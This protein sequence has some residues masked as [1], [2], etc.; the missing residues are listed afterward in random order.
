[1]FGEFG[2]RQGPYKNFDKEKEQWKIWRE[3]ILKK[4]SPDSSQ[5]Q[6][7]EQDQ[8]EVEELKKK[9]EEQRKKAEEQDQN[10]P[11]LNQH[12]QDQPTEP[13]NKDNSPPP[14]TQENNNLPSSTEIQ[15]NYNSDNNPNLTNPEQK[16]QANELL[17]LIITAELLI[18]ET[19]FDSETLSKLTK[20]KEESTTSYQ[21]LNK[22]GRIDKVI[23]AL[24][25]IQKSQEDKN[26]LVAE[27]NKN[28]PISLSTK[29]FLGTA[30][31][32]GS[33]ILGIVVMQIIKR[34]KI[35]R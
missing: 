31:I 35:K 6:Q 23:N 20:E 8:K 26:N 10:N 29:I 3:A 19:K 1:L 2:F 21:T 18:K 16:E 14:P 17:K 27:D 32:V 34:K 25:S 13:T 11:P 5:P 30:I 22:E 9:L 4:N 12:K 28:P 7:S 33:L 24:E 15:N